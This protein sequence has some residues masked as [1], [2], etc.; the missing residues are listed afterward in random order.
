MNRAEH[1]CD[2]QVYTRPGAAYVPAHPFTE[3]EVHTLS[4][5]PSAL[6][7]QR[8]GG[9]ISKRGNPGSPLWL[10]AVRHALHRT[11]GSSGQTRH[12]QP[13][14]TTFNITYRRAARVYSRTTEREKRA[15]TRTWVQRHAAALCINNNFHSFSY[16]IR[17]IVGN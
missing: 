9:G 5:Q 7:A 8:K 12:A 11:S 16:H 17:Q 3:A 6:S 4:R 15:I 10:R 2:L 14:L 1:L 13:T